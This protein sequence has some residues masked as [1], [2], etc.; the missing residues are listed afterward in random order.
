MTRRFLLAAAVAA[1][2]LATLP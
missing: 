1:V 2:A